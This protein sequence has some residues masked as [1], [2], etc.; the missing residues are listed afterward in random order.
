MFSAADRLPFLPVY[1]FDKVYNNLV[2][3]IDSADLVNNIHNKR[4]KE[5]IKYVA[6]PEYNYGFGKITVSIFKGINLGALW[7]D[8]C[9]TRMVAENH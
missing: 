9:L 3:I 6:M 1:P 7:M 2:Q 4:F 8:L 5:L